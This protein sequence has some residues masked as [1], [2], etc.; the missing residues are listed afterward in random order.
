MKDALVLYGIL[1]PCLY[2]FTILVLGTLWQ[3]YNPVSQYLSE[4][5]TTLSP[6]NVFANTILL[7]LSL[8]MLVLAFVFKQEFKKNYSYVFLTLAGIFNLILALFPCDNYCI[9]T[10]F[11]GIVHSISSSLFS[12]SLPLSIFALL[13]AIKKHKKTMIAS[14]SLAIIAL[15]AGAMMHAPALFSYI[16][17]LQRIKIITPVAGLMIVSFMLYKKE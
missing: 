6:N 3:N 13:P 9:N 4:L 8:S 1:I 17:L 11:T 7:M 2:I 5:G 16:G 12:I 14:L 10:T 15:L